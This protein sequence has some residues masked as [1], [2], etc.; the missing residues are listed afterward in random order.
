MIDCDWIFL[1]KDGSRTTATLREP[2]LPMTGNGKMH[3][4]KGYQV[5]FTGDK[6]ISNVNPIILAV[7]H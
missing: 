3:S 7:E 1:N 5:V 2:S 4:G 6:L